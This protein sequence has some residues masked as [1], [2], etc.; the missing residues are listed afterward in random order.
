M[1]ATKTRIPLPDSYAKLIFATQ[2]HL[3]G[4][5][6]TNR[7]SPYVFGRTKNNL[8]IFDIEQ[9]WEK[10]ILAARAIVGLSCPEN[11]CAISAR[12]FGRKPV[13][14]FSER[15]QTNYFKI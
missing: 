12:I 9:A 1:V 14:K 6:I 4:T 8:S 2:S 5:N 11:I 7:M 15:L 3:G 13:L 10:Y